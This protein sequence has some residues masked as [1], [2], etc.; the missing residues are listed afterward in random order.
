LRQVEKIKDP[1][2]LAKVIL[3]RKG[4]RAACFASY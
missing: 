1:N 2:S 4:S 3:Y